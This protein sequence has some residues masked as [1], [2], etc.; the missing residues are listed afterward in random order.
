[1]MQ[2]LVY[3]FTCVPTQRFSIAVLVSATTQE[4][5]TSNNL[6]KHYTCSANVKSLY[7]EELEKYNS[8]Q[9]NRDF[10]FIELVEVFFWD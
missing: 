10:F 8:L 5:S 3:V 1:M 6:S 2:V 7:D 4:A 9:L